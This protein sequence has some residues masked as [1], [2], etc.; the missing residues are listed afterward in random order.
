MSD[1]LE[2]AIFSSRPPTSSFESL[3]LSYIAQILGL[4]RKVNELPQDP[5]F[6]CIDCE[7]YQWDQDKVTEIGIAVLDSRDCM[8]K[9]QNEFH[10]TFDP[11]NTFDTLTRSMKHAHY[12]PVEHGSYVNTKI[13]AYEENFGFGMSTWIHLVDAPKILQRIFHDPA[14]ISTAAD[15][16]VPDSSQQPARNVIIVGHDISNDEGYLR[17]VGFNV[18]SMTNKV[19]TV[20]TQRF[21]PGGVHRYALTKLLT[22]MDIKAINLHN[23]GNDAAYT[24]QALVRMAVLELEESGKVMERMAALQGRGTKYV[25]PVDRTAKAQVAWGGTA[26]QEE[27]STGLV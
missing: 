5:V 13:L 27:T 8:L 16:S 3:D 18:A 1:V 25:F 17:K 22:A 14:A 12:R 26:E 11:T 21:C 2:S 4:T 9:F 24:L 15:F 7:A 6:V 10:A 19:A 20:D 23:G